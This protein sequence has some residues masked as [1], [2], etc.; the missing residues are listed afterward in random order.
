M[1]RVAACHIDVA[2]EKTVLRSYKQKK[3][4]ENLNLVTAAYW[5]GAALLWKEQNSDQQLRVG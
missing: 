4:R 5:N 1:L 2:F 3:S